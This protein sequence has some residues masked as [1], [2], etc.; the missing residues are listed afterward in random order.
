[1][2]NF[3]DCLRSRQ[4]PICDIETGHR[5]A[6]ECHLAQI[7]LRLGRKL[8]WNVEREEFTGEGA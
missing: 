3:F 6:S 4:D 1:M 2:R 8:R 7:A 5:S